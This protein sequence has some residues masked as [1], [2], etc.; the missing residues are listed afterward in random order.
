MS[1]QVTVMKFGGTSVED[2]RAFERVARIVLAHQRATPVVVVSAMSGVTDALMTSLGMA[3]K[4]EISE[5]A[6]TVEG[7]LE[8]HLKVTK[9][10][11]SDAGARMQLLIEIVRREIL[12]VLYI[13]ARS[14][15]TT[16]PQQDMITSQ[17]E[18]L[19]A[20]L[21]AMVLEEFGLPASYVDARNCIITNADHGSA[22][23]LIRTTARRTRATL[24]PLLAARKIPVLGGFIGATLKGLTT[25]L[26]R[27]SSDYTATLVSAALETREIQIWTDVN[28]VQTA[29]PSLVKSTRTV[30]HLSYTEAAELAR[31]GANVLHPK[32]IQP[33]LREKTPIRICNSRA[34]EQSGT[35]ICSLGKTSPHTV[36]AIAH[37]T[38][39]A[40]IDIASARASVANGFLHALKKVFNRHQRHMEIV[41]LTKSGISL[42]CDEGLALSSLVLD[43]QEIGAVRIRRHRAMI[44]C[45]GE[46]LLSAPGSAQKVLN[47]AS[48]ID[49]T[50]AWR[51][52]SSINL[53]SMVRTDSVRSIVGRLHEEIFE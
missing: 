6:Q 7:H 17:G 43:L 9:G 8:R 15:T 28:G 30:S 47:I 2:G 18:R 36:K 13:A 39:F 14:R 49:S 45:V 24:K 52:T 41:A 44:S 31:L 26:G 53:M 46:G 25:T 29:D 40:R 4:G 12:E 19:S 50:L 1:I 33:V 51:S 32:T 38:N 48:D 22:K 16:A 10:L 20:N 27:G 42:A 5:A 21:L 35:L 34:P 37:Q 23:P 3:A 11:G